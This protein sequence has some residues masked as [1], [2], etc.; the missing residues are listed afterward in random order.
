MLASWLGP[1]VRARTPPD[2]MARLVRALDATLADPG[3]RLRLAEAGLD[4]AADSTADGFQ[5]M[6]R[7]NLERWKAVAQRA[8]LRQ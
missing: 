5:R 2:R 6:T 3:I 4:I 7:A 8:G 1:M